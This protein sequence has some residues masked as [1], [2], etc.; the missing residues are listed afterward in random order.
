MS[1]TVVHGLLILACAL[2]PLAACGDDGEQARAKKA[3]GALSDYYYR[4]WQAPSPEW[5]VMRVR[6]GK[7]NHLTVDAS[8]TTEALTKTVMERSRFEQMEIA[9]MAC[10]ERRHAIWK[11]IGREQVVGVALSGT[12]G[13]IINALCKRP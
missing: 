3:A 4:A 12:A 7:E 1:R 9:R 13:H 8:I 10:P 6:I 2:P 5:S 11:D